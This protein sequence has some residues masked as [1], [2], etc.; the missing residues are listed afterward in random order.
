MIVLNA[1][2][3]DDERINNK[4]ILRNIIKIFSLIIFELFCIS[5]VKFLLCIHT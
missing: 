5:S 1:K 3:N 4:Q 2:M